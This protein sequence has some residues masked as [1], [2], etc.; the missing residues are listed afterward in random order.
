MLPSFEIKQKYDLHNL[1]EVDEFHF[2]IQCPQYSDYRNNYLT[3]LQSITSD[4]HNIENNLK[5][6]ILIHEEG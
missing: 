3:R 6:C 2:L 1:D 4:F 5:L